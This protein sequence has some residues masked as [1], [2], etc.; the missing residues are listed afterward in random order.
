MGTGAKIDWDFNKD[1]SHIVP[2][3]NIYSQIDFTSSNKKSNR[4][5]SAG[6]SREVILS[7][8]LVNPKPK[9]HYIW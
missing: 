9:L 1:K 7:I 2:A 5:Y 6:H 3:P 8:I 4:G